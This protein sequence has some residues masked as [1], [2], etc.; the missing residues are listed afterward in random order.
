MKTDFSKHLKIAEL[1]AIEA[2]KILLR[3]QS[4]LKTSEVQSKKSLGLVTKADLLAEKKIKEILLKEYKNSLFL[5]E[6]ETF[7][8]KSQPSKF[9]Q[10]YDDHELTWVVDPLD[11]TTNF[12]HSLECYCVCIGLLHYGKPVMG[13][14][15]RP[16]SGE[17]YFARNGKGSFKKVLG[18]SARPKKLWVSDEKRRLK[19]CLLAT[20]FATEKGKPLDQEFA[21]FFEIMKRSRGVRRLGSAALDLC[22]VAEGVFQ[23]FWEKNLAP[24]DIT[25]A[26]VIC[27]EANVEMMDYKKRPFNP[28]QKSTIACHPGVSKSLTKQI[29]MFYQN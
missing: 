12:V 6:E 11:G 18:R 28:F 29:T 14:V 2:G 7:Q 8:N 24:W 3:F 9:K 4:K 16:Y 22:L 23:G 20:G 5:G 17:V 15:Y 1:A 27:L 25:A 19:D 26:A 10:L 13:L 21:L